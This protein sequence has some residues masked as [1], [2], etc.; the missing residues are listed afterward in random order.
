M[1]PEP[2]SMPPF[3]RIVF[4]LVILALL[5]VILVVYFAPADDLPPEVV[6][7]KSSSATNGQFVE[8]QRLQSRTPGTKE[9]PRTSGKNS[10]ASVPPPVSAA[11]KKSLIQFEGRLKELEAK[12]AK[13]VS[14][15]IVGDGSKAKV[16]VSAPSTEEIALMSGIMAREIEGLPS[17]ER[18]NARKLLQL[19]YDDYTGFKKEFRVLLS[20][21]ADA[22][23]SIMVMVSDVSSPDS[24]SWSS[25]QTFHHDLRTPATENRFSHIFKV[26]AE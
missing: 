10:D 13:F 8:N 2:I 20:I 14:E 15:S 5:S 7:S 9:T 6:L 18:L 11:I 3:P 4:L 12:R 25:M 23:T 21:K 16:V 26:D 17:D 1:S 22:A 19:K 24:T